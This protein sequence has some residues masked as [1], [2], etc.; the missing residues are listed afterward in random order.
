MCGYDHIGELP[1]RIYENLRGRQPIGELVHIHKNSGEMVGVTIALRFG[2][3]F[4]VFVAPEFRG[5]SLERDLIEHAAANTSRFIGAD[6]PYVLTDAFSCDSRRLEALVAAGFEH[7]R[8]WDNVNTC[9]LT[10]PLPLPQIATVEG[11]VVRSATHADAEQL[12]IAH[13]SAFDDSWTGDLYLT[14]VMQKPGYAPE[15][16]IV[17]A[18]PDGR[19]ASFAVYW[20]DHKNKVGH[21]EPVGTHKDFQRKGLARAAMVEAMHQMKAAGMESVTVNHDA[22]NLAAMKLYEGLGFKKRYE[23]YGFRRPV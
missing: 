16:E 2:S 5:T 9:D 23:T 10:Q 1:H 15:R 8:T 20:M 3:A 19:I 7:F 18:T 14:E 13:N 6:E 11:L 17:T 4:D 12:A 22:E 21:F